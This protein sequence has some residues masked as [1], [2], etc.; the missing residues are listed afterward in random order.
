[1]PQAIIYERLSSLGN[2]DS[3]RDKPQTLSIF[4]FILDQIDKPSGICIMSPN[5][6]AIAFASA[7]FWL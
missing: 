6:K 4:I 5:T 7:W 1:M 2:T 3:L